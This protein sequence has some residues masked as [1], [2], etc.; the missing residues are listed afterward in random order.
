MMDGPN[1]TDAKCQRKHTQLTAPPKRRRSMS[2]RRKEANKL[3]NGLAG[4]V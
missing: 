4:Q 2:Y 1:S 3:A